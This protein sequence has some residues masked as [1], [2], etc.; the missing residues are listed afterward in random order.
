MSHLSLVLVAS[1][2]LICCG[3]EISPVTTTTKD[4]PQ[5]IDGLLTFRLGEEMR[6]RTS[7]QDGISYWTNGHL[8]SFVVTRTGDSANPKFKNCFVEQIHGNE[9]KISQLNIGTYLN[10]QYPLIVSS[11]NVTFV[12]D[13]WD[14]HDVLFDTRVPEGT[15]YMNYA[16][17]YGLNMSRTLISLDTSIVVDTT[18][19]VG[20]CKL[21][22]EKITIAFGH[23]WLFIKYY[24]S[25]DGRIA[26][27]DYRTINEYGY[28]VFNGPINERRETY[29][30]ASIVAR[31]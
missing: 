18:G 3:C 15:T 14:I 21:F 5:Q 25:K 28:D 29:L 6:Y 7:Y 26:R 20:S 17:G 16:N 24:V 2:F 8:D 1:L 31:Q 9:A 13:F 19:T 22:E 12:N 10:F 30:L 27:F 4:I 11:D 23:E